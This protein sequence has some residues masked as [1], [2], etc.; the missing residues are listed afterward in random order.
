M[1]QYCCGICGVN[2]VSGIN[3][4]KLVK[5]LEYLTHLNIDEFWIDSLKQKYEGDN[6]CICLECW[7]K[8]VTAAVNCTSFGIIERSKYV[9]LVKEEIAQQLKECDA[10]N[11]V[12]LENSK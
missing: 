1:P 5:A 8:F 4:M 10:L 3:E 9:A 7:L 11:T 2:K 12:S 6:D